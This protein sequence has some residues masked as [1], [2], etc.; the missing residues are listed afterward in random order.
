MAKKQIE[1]EKENV[2]E[3]SETEKKIGYAAAK[4]FLHIIQMD[5]QKHAD[6][7]EGMLEVLKGKPPSK[8]LWEHKLESYVDPIVVKKE[9]ERHMER[10]SQMIKHVEE[11]IEET[12][13]EGLRM[14]LEFIVE[15]ERKHHKMLAA[16]IKRS[17]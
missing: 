17:Y 5:S 2:K 12:K 6:A 3:V 11:E 1:I 10:E 8:N 13:D 16:I 9:L 14:L 15:D 4:L 7:L